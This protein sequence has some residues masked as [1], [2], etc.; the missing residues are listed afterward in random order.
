MKGK[1]LL[2][3]EYRYGRPGPVVLWQ[4]RKHIYILCK[5]SVKITDIPTVVKD[6][7]E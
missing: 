1:L 2:K 4:Q 7:K 3:L 6:S 5:E